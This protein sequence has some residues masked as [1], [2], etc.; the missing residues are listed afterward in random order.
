MHPED[1]VHY[2]MHMSFIKR[3]ISRIKNKNIYDFEIKN[4]FNNYVQA[5]L[6]IACSEDVLI[7]FDDNPM[8]HTQLQVS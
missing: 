8:I 1:E 5:M 6:D 4:Y 7:D 3:I 2:E